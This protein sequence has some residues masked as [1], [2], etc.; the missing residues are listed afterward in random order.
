MNLYLKCLVWVWVTLTGGH[1]WTWEAWVA[2]CCH[3]QHRITARL[4][5]V[6]QVALA[7]AR[8]RRCLHFTHNVLHLWRLS[9]SLCRWLFHVSSRP[10][11]P[12]TTTTLPL[13]LRESADPSSSS[14]RCEELLAAAFTEGA[15]A[16][17]KIKIVKTSH[18]NTLRSVSPKHFLTQSKTEC[19][20]LDLCHAAES[21]DGFHVPL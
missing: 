12:T 15:A 8:P 10:E 9:L 20:S 16:T 2:G 18:R 21:S 1:R 5:P 11:Q 3:P 7:A 14:A 4:F 13:C 17:N 6:V 19:V